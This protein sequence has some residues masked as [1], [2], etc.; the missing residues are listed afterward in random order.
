MFLTL[1]SLKINK[2]KNRE[3]SGIGVNS[4]RTYRKVKLEKTPKSKMF[5]LFHK[6]VKK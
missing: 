4:K 6:A 2:I 5:R 3:N 1:Q